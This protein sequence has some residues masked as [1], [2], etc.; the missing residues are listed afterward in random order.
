MAVA[1]G[2]VNQRRTRAQKRR[3]KIHAIGGNAAC[4]QISFRRGD[5]GLF[6][7]RRTY[8]SKSYLEDWA[9]TGSTLAFADW[10]ESKGVTPL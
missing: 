5:K 9:R 7:N 6:A 1:R 3:G 2:E 4:S 8:P 10:L